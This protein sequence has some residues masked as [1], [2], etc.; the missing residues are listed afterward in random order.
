MNTLEAACQRLQAAIDRLE[1]A[2]NSHDD[3]ERGAR[4]QLDASLQAAHAERA[5]LSE[6][7]RTTLERLDATIGRL[8]G[9]LAG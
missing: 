6:V 7:N 9:L 3:R 1:S 2:L 5:T 4:A 8:R